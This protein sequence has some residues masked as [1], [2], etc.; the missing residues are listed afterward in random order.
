MGF[1]FVTSCAHCALCKQ[2]KEVQVMGVVHTREEKAYYSTMLTRW[3]SQFVDQQVFVRLF[4]YC[5]GQYN[6]GVVLSMLK[7]TVTVT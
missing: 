6:S 5:V 1:V 3:P 4:F 2:T 7:K